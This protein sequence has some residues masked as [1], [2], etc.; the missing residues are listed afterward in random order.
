MYSKILVPLDG[1]QRA[2]RVLPHVEEMATCFKATVIFL[3]AVEYRRIPV[4]THGESLL[5]DEA[6]TMEA[7]RSAED[8]LRGLRGEF[9]EKGINAR[10]M[11]EQGRPV[12]IIC[13]VAERE[14]VDLI[15][16]ASH[17]RGGV[18]RVFYGSVAAAVLQRV[19]RA[20]LLIRSR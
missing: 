11:V 3:Q 6:A 9:R 19:D 8:Y 12:D 16:M 17:G 5:I 10:L 4:A 2:E 13:N 18:A 14:N 15:A 1:S 7:A 20:L